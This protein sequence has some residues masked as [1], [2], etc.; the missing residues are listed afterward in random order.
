MLHRSADLLCLLCT[1]VVLLVM[2][3]GQRCDLSLRAG[4]GVTPEDLHTLVLMCF[5]CRSTKH[6]CLCLA[7]LPLYKAELDSVLITAPSLNTL[8]TTIHD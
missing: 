2:M 6:S 1:F 8:L 5:G 4:F 7:L 3:L